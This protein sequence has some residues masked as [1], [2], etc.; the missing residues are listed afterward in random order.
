MAA[1]HYFQRYSQKENVATNNTL[2]LFTR[3]YQYSSM[4]FANFISE[5]LDDAEV[6]PGISFIQQRK[7]S[8]S[9]P[10]AVVSQ[11]SFKIVIETKLSDQFNLEQLEQ[12]LSEFRNEEKKILLLLGA[13]K[14]NKKFLSDLEEK[15]TTSGHKDIRYKA[16][17]F[18]DVVDNFRIVI[19]S[20][21]FEMQEIIDDYEDYCR[22]AT[23]NLIDVGDSWLR[24]MTCGWSIKENTE[25]GIYYDKIE[26][27]Y[28]KHK[29]IGF[30]SNKSVKGIGVIENIVAATLNAD[31]NLEISEE[32]NTVT[33][34]Q[35]SRIKGIIA[36]AMA[37]NKWDISKDHRFF[38]ADKFHE[39]DFRKTTSGGLMR[40]KYF[41]LLQLL[42]VK[43]LP[44]TEKIAE[45]LKTKTWE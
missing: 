22:G 27:N 28:S 36:A 6:E 2:L 14:P 7:S 10:D 17:T 30:Y 24:V 11:A 32:L 1:V 4:L 44:P 9:V 19:P 33:E 18:K 3:L 31:G 39:T 5:L 13:G 12:H 37:N 8:K 41:D 40:S 15:I 43:K 35:K 23:P 20:H 25:F 38:C 42:G 26:R 21:A 45:E 29:Y 16:L 34:L